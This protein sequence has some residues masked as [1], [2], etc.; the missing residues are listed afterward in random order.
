[1]NDSMTRIKLCGMTREEDIACINRLQ[2][3]YVGFV[4]WPKSKRYVTRERALELRRLLL[5]GITPVGVFVDEDPAVIAGLYRDGIIAAAQLH[6]NE[7]DADILALQ[8][9]GIPVIRAY[10]VT[11][12]EDVQ[13]AVASPADYIMFDPGKGDGAVFNWQL[14]RP[15]ER[16]YFL[17]GGLTPENVGQA[18]A[19]LHPWAVDV[20]S[21]IES[22]GKKDALK[23]EAFV[24]QVRKEDMK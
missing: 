11:C 22:E 9:D 16:P 21:G 3:Q 23:M 8:A 15:V 1:M 17:A 14:I 12:E 4:F 19:T 7:S 2:P 13:R 5:E 20:S 24:S 6:G 18:I 10:K